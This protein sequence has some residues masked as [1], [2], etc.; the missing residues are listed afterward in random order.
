MDQAPQADSTA[1]RAGPEQ[2]L[3]AALPGWRAVGRCRR[4]MAGASGISA[5]CHAL[6]H[7]AIGVAL[8]DLVPQVTPNAEARLRRALDAA[9]F[10]DLCP[11]TLP[12]WHGRVEP[13]QLR[14]LPDILAEGFDSLPPLGLGGPEGW[15]GA[16]QAALARDPAWEVPGR[17]RSPAKEEGKAK[18][19]EAPLPRRRLPRWA[20]ASLALVV[21]LVG[22][23]ALLPATPAPTSPDPAPAPVLAALPSQAAPAPIPHALPQIERVELPVIRPA[24]PPPAPEPEPVA[25]APAA[26]AMPPP[27][28][29]PPVP[30][31]DLI[32]PPPA[33]P[34]PPPVRQASAPRPR[35]D[36]NCSRAL[37]RFQQGERLSSAEEAYVRNG[38]ATRR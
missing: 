17:P 2:R 22:G 27:D 4:G 32:A 14:R 29:T 7:P 34:P 38:C 8:I 24:A 36:P 23:I 18:E 5:G 33:P 11:G 28:P 21:C 26:S 31:P 30:E 1:S 6:A 12:V 9:S 35:I 19:A 25:E 37:F 16:V 13:M 15:I 10:S 20:V 3:L